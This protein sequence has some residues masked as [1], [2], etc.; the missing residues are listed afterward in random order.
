MIKINIFS[1]KQNESGG[2]FIKD[3]ES[4]IN[5]E[6]IVAIIKQT[7]QDLYQVKTVRGSIY[8]D[9]RSV[10]RILKETRNYDKRSKPTSD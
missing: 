8:I 6:N 1:W 10:T 2:L 3:E 9:K 7:K 5:P 4:Y